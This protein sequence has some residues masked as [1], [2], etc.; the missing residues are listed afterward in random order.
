MDRSTLLQAHQKV[1]ALFLALLLLLAP[2]EGYAQE[3]GGG[4]GAKQA[5]EQGPKQDLKAALDALFD[6]KRLQGAKLSVHVRDV[7]SGDTLYGRKEDALLNPAS[8]MKLVTAAAMLD[9][10]GPDFTYT[11]EL[12]A[13]G[14]RGDVITGDLAIKGNGD[15]FL[16]W[17]H[18]LELAER[19][20]RKGVREVKGDLLVDDTAFDP[21]YLPP[22]FDQKDEDDAFR[23]PVSAVSANFGAMNVLVIPGEV[24]QPPSVSF[25]P[26]CDYADVENKALTVKSK[27]ETAKKPLT[28]EVRAAGSRTKVIIGGTTTPEGGATVRKRVEDPSIYT[29]FLLKRALETMGV[30]VLGEVKRGAAPKDKLMAKHSS[31]QLPY[32]LAAMQKW[33]NNFMAEGLFKSLDL[34]DEPASWEDAAE[35]VRQFV[36]KTGV[37]GEFKVVNGSGLYDANRFSASQLTRILAYMDKREDV[38]AEYEASFAI[39]GVDGTLGDR[40]KKTPAQGTLRGKT[41]TLNEVVSLSGYAYTKSGRKL[42]FSVLFNEASGGAWSYRKVQDELGAILSGL[43]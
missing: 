10:L 13:S 38:R 22:A 18:L 27:D 36:K 7:R 37:K 16:E 28:V 23:A 14:L 5:K 15:P 29:G 30:K 9:H 40:M 34:G 32:L 35:V 26:P 3:G 20:A 39:A 8:N 1:G 2:R 4:K 12:W 24:G 31:Y 6:D 41:G 11:T 25:D 43:D 33:S 42:A 21:R 19:V 17:S